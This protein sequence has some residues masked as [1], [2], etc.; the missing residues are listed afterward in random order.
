MKRETYFARYASRFTLHLIM[1]DTDY[2]KIAYHLAL[3]GKGKTS[4]NPLVGALLVKGS[5]IIAQGWHRRCGGP[6]AEIMALK[7][8]GRRA[9]GARLYVTLEPC[10]HFGRTPPCVDVIMKSG[11]RQVV[12]GMKDPN[13]LTRGKSIATLKKNGIKVKSLRLHS[14]QADFLKKELKDMNEA[15]EKYI[16]YNY[17][18]VVAKTAQTLDGKIATANGQSKWITGKR[19]RDYARELRNDFDAILVGI[20]TVLKD[21][22]GLNATGRSKR[23][24]KIILDSSLRIPLKAK[25]FRNTRPGDCIIATTKRAD[26]KK[27]K[28][29][30]KRGV[31]VMICPTSSLS[32]GTR[33]GKRRRIHIKWLLK[34]LA[35]QEI[36]SILF[37]GGAQVIG[38]ALKE[39]IVDKMI[40]FVAPK[41]MGDQ[42]ALGSVEGF[43]ISHVDRA[44]RLKETCIKKIGQDFLIKGKVVY[45]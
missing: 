2:M 18:F 32:E 40:I 3:K 14:G 25:L 42:R 10:F 26:Q 5:K 11:L 27:L 30:R 34:E 37:E 44:L 4:P 8:A 39:K 31:N 21:N 38:S 9:Q 43:N 35:K 7:R 19:T 23:L 1:T 28:L 15:F 6:H 13:P 41:I 33:S 12:I 36:T 17:P 20:H 22:P 45:P 16:K 24:K 29:L